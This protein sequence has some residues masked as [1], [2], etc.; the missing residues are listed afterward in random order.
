MASTSR[1][2]PR[3]ATESGAC[4]DSVPMVSA[5]APVRCCTHQAAP[6]TIAQSAMSATMPRISDAPR[7]WPGA[8]RAASNARARPTQSEAASAALPVRPDKAANRAWKIVVGDI[9]LRPLDHAGR[10]IAHDHM[11]AAADG[12]A[13]LH[14]RQR[15]IEEGLLLRLRPARGQHRVGHVRELG[16]QSGLGR[17]RFRGIRRQGGGPRRECRRAAGRR[18]VRSRPAARGCPS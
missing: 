16:A 14:A 8:A 5:R 11:V 12:D 18:R 6:T 15:A 7:A 3:T 4:T 1:I 17:R 2:S 10:G 13:A 9:L